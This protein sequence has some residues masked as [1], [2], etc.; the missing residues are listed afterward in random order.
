VSILAQPTSTAFWWVAACFVRHQARA[1]L[2]IA[3]WLVERRA[4]PTAPSDSFQLRHLR[5]K[6]RLTKSWQTVQLTSTSRLVWN[7]LGL[8]SG[9]E[10]AT[11]QKLEKQ[12]IRGFQPSPSSLMP[13]LQLGFHSG[14]SHHASP[15]SNLQNA[16]TAS[17]PAVTRTRPRSC[18]FQRSPVLPLQHLHP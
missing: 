17:S 7:A 11:A 16:V 13:E 12:A 1:P 9:Q 5:Q 8:V 15:F 4:E 14:C 3:D 6:Q 2:W 10:V 18:T